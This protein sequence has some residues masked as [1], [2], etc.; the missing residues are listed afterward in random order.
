M[1]RVRCG[2]SGSGE[3]DPVT[4]FTGSVGGESAF[5][6]MGVGG[7]IDGFTGAAIEDSSP[8]T[9]LVLKRMGAGS[10]TIA[11]TAVNAHPPIT[12]V[13]TA[14]RTRRTTIGSINA[15]RT[16]FMVLAPSVAVAI[17]VLSTHR[18]LRLTTRSSDP[19]PI[20]GAV[21]AMH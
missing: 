5:A 2:R 10:W 15:I 21:L 6:K 7:R 12:I 4:T 3:I 14:Q 17:A 9:T 18:C 16:S 13:A 19:R 1:W 8:R 20:R 11:Q